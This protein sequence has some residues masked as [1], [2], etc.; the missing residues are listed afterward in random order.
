[1]LRVAVLCILSTLTLSA[2]SGSTTSD[3]SI[4]SRIDGL[5]YYPTVPASGYHVSRRT[6][7]EVEALLKLAS[8]E[9][10]RNEAAPLQRA[11]DSNNEAGM[12][13]IVSGLQN[14]VCTSIGIP[15]VT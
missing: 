8:L 12:V 3:R 13:R 15:P 6:A 1:V 7:M 2:C 4:C 11:I 10:L 5:F 9:G 14:S